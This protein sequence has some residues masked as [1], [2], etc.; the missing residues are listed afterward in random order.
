MFRVLLISMFFSSAAMAATTQDAG[1]VG[2][3]YAKNAGWWVEL[4]TG[5]PNALADRTCRLE[6]FFTAS[7]N[8]VDVVVYAAQNALP[9]TVISTRCLSTPQAGANAYHLIETVWVDP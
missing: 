2:R 6:L 8:V 4:S 3:I 7:K 5:M 9:V 1:N